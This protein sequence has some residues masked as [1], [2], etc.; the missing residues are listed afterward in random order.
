[1][2]RDLVLQKDVTKPAAVGCQI[3]VV[4]YQNS[5]VF[6]RLSTLKSSRNGGD[7]VLMMFR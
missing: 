3:L 5:V 7:T 2:R 4:L 6:R 1:M